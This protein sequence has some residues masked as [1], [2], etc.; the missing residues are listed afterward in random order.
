M[1]NVFS[2]LTRNIAIAGDVAEVGVLIVRVDLLLQRF[3]SRHVHV[4]LGV[5]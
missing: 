2:Y 3:E 1:K 4:Y 5:H